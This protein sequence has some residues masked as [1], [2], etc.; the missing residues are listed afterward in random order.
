M[1]KTVGVEIASRSLLDSDILPSQVPEDSPGS[2]LPWKSISCRRI[3][4]EEIK[5]KHIT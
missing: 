3:G 2:I 1:Q 4:S 5:R